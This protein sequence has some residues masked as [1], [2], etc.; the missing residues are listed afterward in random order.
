MRVVS[1]KIYVPFLGALCKIIEPNIYGVY[2]EVAKVGYKDSFS[3]F[4]VSALIPVTRFG[5]V[6]REAMLLVQKHLRSFLSDP[7]SAPLIAAESIPEHHV[8]DKLRKQ[9][10]LAFLEVYDAGIKETVQ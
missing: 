2:Y 3:L 9:C 6:S 8:K 10:A 4:K 7:G 1:H 5:K